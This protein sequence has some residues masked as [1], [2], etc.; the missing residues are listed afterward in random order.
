M[1]RDEDHYPLLADSNGHLFCDLDRDPWPCAAEL[2]RR[3]SEE[4]RWALAA[5]YGDA[6]TTDD[7][8]DPLDP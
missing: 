5:A 7:D 1:T 6:I 8:G 3:A 4:A 2:R